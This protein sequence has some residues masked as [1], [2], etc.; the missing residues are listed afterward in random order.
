MSRYTKSNLKR[1]YKV[2]SLA[3]GIATPTPSKYSLYVARILKIAREFNDQGRSFPVWGTCLG[4]ESLLIALSDFDLILDVDL[5]DNMVNHS[6]NFN[7]GIRSFFDD[8][9]TEDD[10]ASIRTSELMF[11]NHNFGFRMEKIKASK[12]VT[13]NIDI[14]STV[15]T[16]HNEEVLAGFKH[17]QYPF[18][19]IQYHPEASQ[20]GWGDKHPFNK[21]EQANE[22]GLKHALVFRA[23]IQEPEPRM[24]YIEVFAARKKIMY[25]SQKIDELAKFYILPSFSGEVGDI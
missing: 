18:Y 19:G 16:T 2:G 9:M 8:M 24:S 3:A 5:A 22:M 7:R 1:E 12:F 23:L 13:E 14:L 21:S 10:F 6:V 25:S 17:K 11:F 20:F 4:F 15:K